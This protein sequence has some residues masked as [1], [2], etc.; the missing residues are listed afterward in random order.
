MK[1]LKSFFKFESTDWSAEEILKELSIQMS[2]AGLYV[3]FPND[4]KFDGKFYL[5]IED[6]DRVFCKKYPEDDM[7]WLHGKPIIDKLFQ[8]LKDFGLV[9]DKHYKVYAGGLGVNIVFDEKNLIKL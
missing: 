7:D 2:D 9:R 4:N 6:R 5:S 8:E 1:Y 3:E